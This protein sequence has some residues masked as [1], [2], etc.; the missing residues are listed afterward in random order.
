MQ[1]E[2]GS[3]F[4]CWARPLALDGAGRVGA[5]RPDHKSAHSLP[6][7]MVKKL[8]LQILKREGVRSA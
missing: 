6:F 7:V 1:I 4:A 2:F 5:G 3:A 8:I